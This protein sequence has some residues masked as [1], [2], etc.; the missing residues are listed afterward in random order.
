MLTVEQTTKIERQPN[1]ALKLI[2][3][4]GISARKMRKLAGI[5]T[6]EKKR[7]EGAC[8]KFARNSIKTPRSEHWLEA[9]QSP[10]YASRS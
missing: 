8:L 10:G 1:Q 7:E 5:E 6:L 3:G 2:Y 9:E 4:P